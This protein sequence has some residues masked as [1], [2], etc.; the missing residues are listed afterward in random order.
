MFAASGDYAMMESW[1]SLRYLILSVPQSLLLYLFL[2]FIFS[3]A[4]KGKNHSSTAF[5][6]DWAS[7]ILEKKCSI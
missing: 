6:L 5:K 1:L 7:P 2:Y 4:I 3:L